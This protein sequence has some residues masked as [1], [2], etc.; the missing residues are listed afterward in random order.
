MAPNSASRFIAT[1]PIDD[2]AIDI[3]KSRA[4]VE[5]SPATDEQTLL[6]LAEGTIGIV[7][8]SESQVT[9]RLMDACTMLKVIGRPG[10]GFD[11]VDVDAATERGIPVVYAPVGGF[12]VA[13]SAMAL[14]LGLVKKLQLNDKIVRQGSWT[15]RHDFKTGDLAD[16]TL[17]VVGL[18]RIGARVV[19][20]AQAFDMKVIGHDP[21]ATAK[22]AE[23]LR[24]ELVDLETL[25]G[26]SDY[27]SL[28]VPLNNETRGLINRQRISIMKEGAILINTARGGV[29]ESLDVLAAALQ[30][31]QLSAIGLDVYPAEPPDQS[32]PIFRDPRCL[33]APHMLAIS[34]LAMKRIYESMA[35]D[36][37]A[38]IDGRRPTH[39]VNPDV[40]G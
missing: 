15:Q 13:E 39:C 9:A 23:E 3:L 5:I 38:V 37:V 17:G 10:A 14:L 7:N 16:H 26:R 8:R 6:G 19:R 28:H 29:I 30:S 27:V 20:L 31:G 4:P 18:G 1:S 35:Q 11:S 12:A 21:I 40:L 36:M 2:T 32:H 33:F 34:E 24:I 25:L 22:T